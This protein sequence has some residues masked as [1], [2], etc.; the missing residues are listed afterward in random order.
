MPE[1]ILRG[2]DYQIYVN[3]H[4]LRARFPTRAEAEEYI[5]EFLIKAE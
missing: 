4:F 5:Y 2:G 3:G 1:V